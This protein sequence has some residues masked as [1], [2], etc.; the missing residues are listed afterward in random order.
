MQSNEPEN[1]LMLT[2]DPISQNIVAMFGM[3]FT[4]RFGSVPD[5]R[6]FACLLVEEANR[7]DNYLDSV[8]R[9]KRRR[10]TIPPRYA[11]KAIREWEEDLEI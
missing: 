2:I 8:S 4:L 3:G 5:I 6:A 11:K 10:N 9:P 7:L 1:D